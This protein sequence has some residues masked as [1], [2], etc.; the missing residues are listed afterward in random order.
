MLPAYSVDSLPTSLF[1]LFI[2][3]AIVAFRTIARYCD[4]TIVVHVEVGLGGIW[5]PELIAFASI[6]LLFALLTWVG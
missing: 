5:S 3:E 6:N 2:E 1:T 4:T